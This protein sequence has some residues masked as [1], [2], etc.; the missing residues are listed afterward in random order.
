MKKILSC[1]ALTTAL[2]LPSQSDAAGFYLQEQST[3]GLGSSFAGEAAMARDASIVYFNPAAMTALDG[4]QF[5]SGVQ[6]IVPTGSVTND[7]SALA[8]VG[9]F[10]LNGNSNSPYNPTPVP[11]FHFA[12][13]LKGN[14]DLWF[15]FSV[16]FPFGLEN[17]YDSNWFGRYDSIKND[18]KTTNIQPSLA[19]K[20]N[21]KLSFGGGIDIQKADVRLTQAVDLGP[22]NENSFSSFDGTD[23]TIGYNLG[24]FYQPTDRLSL[25]AHYRSQVRHDLKLTA[26]TINEANV[27]VL[28]DNGTQAELD[29][30]EIATLAA[31]YDLNEKW[32][33][34]GHVMWFGWSSFDSLTAISSTGTILQDL[35]QNY[36]NT[37][38]F[39]V[40]AEYDH[41]D[42][43]TFRGG[44]QYDQTPTQDGFR[45]TRTPDGDRTWLSVG[46]TYSFNPSLSLD[47]AATYIDVAE[48]QVNVSR[49]QPTT[50][51]ANINAT[52]DQDIQII[53]LGLNKKF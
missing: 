5:N 37:F 46:A 30:P 51:V 10:A 36:T 48:E 29:L 15:G 28:A 8:G 21:D 47:M 53:S 13:P 34:M 18:L 27:T 19:Y 35:Q 26:T 41:S 52:Y 33:V 1:L 9:G 45:S 40:G 43:W 14:T 24:V 38:A 3:S 17:E 20:V 49:T 39:G 11:N 2:V 22:G 6:L 7:G 31:A 25:A 12:T 44:V 23:Y 16:S 4:R 50:R 32:K 42:K